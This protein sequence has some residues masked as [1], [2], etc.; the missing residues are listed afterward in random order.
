MV[1]VILEVVEVHVETL[2]VVVKIVEV[3]VE[4]VLEVVIVVIEEVV[5]VVVEKLYSHNI[6]NRASFVCVCRSSIFLYNYS[7][8]SYPY[9]KVYRITLYVQVIR[10]LPYIKPRPRSYLCFI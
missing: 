10:T 3:V 4:E 8:E 2:L 1:V 6:G 5:E 9:L 7:L